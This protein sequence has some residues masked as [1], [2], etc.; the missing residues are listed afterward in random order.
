M[1]AL[2][3]LTLAN[4]R[5][6][7]RD[8]AAV[9]WTL[10]FPLIFILLFG[11]IFQAGNFRIQLGWADEDG[12]AASADLRAAFEQVGGL[13]L[14][15]GTEDETRAAMA[16]G[17]VDAAVI[18][19]AGFGASLAAAQGGGSTPATMTLLTDAAQ[20]QNSAT[21]T[22]IVNGVIAAVNM[23]GRP[24]FVVAE[25]QSIQ[26]QDLNAI[27]YFVPSIL[28]MSIMQLG[29]F[30]AIPLVADREKLI[31]KR[32]AATPLRRSQLIGSNVAMR[33]LIAA[34]QAMIIV[35]V[36]TL[37]FGVE[38]TGNI[39]LT[40][41]F[42]VLGALVFLALGYV[43]ASFAST[44]DA[45]N[46]MTSMVQFPMMFLSGIFFQID[47]MPSYLQAVARLVPLT[48]LADA[49]RQTMVGGAP[50]VPLPVDA[51]VLGGWLVGCF[52]VASRFFEW[53]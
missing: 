43:I 33:L 45:A 44:E 12:T 42:V 36:G 31:L 30:A 20:A 3:Q 25:G 28:G 18:V 27:S 40:A 51:L 41:G 39:L 16:A 37:L 47:Q 8:R 53:Q 4:I 46:G 19:P 15:S 7:T 9:F 13:E 14:V 6:Y 26:T 21:I 35:G 32:L 22:Q 23:G 52:G 5:S 49:L 48:Y 29:I 34:I 1:R 10:A 50:F 11:F 2:T 38:T 24:P 17:H